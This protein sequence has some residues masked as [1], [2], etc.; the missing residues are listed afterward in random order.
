MSKTVAIS[1][2]SFVI[3]CL[4]FG[5]FY[6]YK[7]INVSDSNGNTSAQE[8]AKRDIPIFPFDNNGQNT[9]SQQSTSTGNNNQNPV[10]IP[11]IRQLSTSPVSGFTFYESSNDGLTVRYMEGE[12]GNII[13]IPFSSVNKERVTNRTLILIRETLWLSG[14][15]GFLSR[16]ADPTS[17]TLNTIFGQIVNN[18]SASTSPKDSSSENLSDIETVA[19]PKGIYQA[20]SIPFDKTQSKNKA[21]KPKIAFLDKINNET[22]VF[23]SNED[24]SVMKQIAY[25][26]I[27]EWKILGATNENVFIQTKPSFN[28]PSLYYS[29][30][31]NSGKLSKVL[32]GPSG[33]S[34][35]LSEKGQYILYSGVTENLPM[36]YY[37]DLK[38]KSTEPLPL[39]TFAD[40]CSF[41]K[42]DSFFICGVPSQIEKGKYPDDW[43]KGITSFKDE[44]WIASPKTGEISQFTTPTRSG[45]TFDIT[46]PK[47]SP[48]KKYLVFINKNDNTLWSVRLPNGLSQTHTNASTTVATTTK[49]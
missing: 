29:I 48:D 44:I 23:I 21:T 40:K 28:Y 36:V 35:V 37:Y 6:W 3:L 49:K 46:N 47:I 39:F 5:I 41:A 11:A 43:Y 8:E 33:S 22:G 17:D 32:N 45:F 30:N 24:G 34:G 12:K 9:S 20:V 26:P 38:K 15:S 14:E 16:F 7:S 27:N 31:I 42:D 13:D 18:S 4:G 10:E 25:L 1:I 19:L 2:I